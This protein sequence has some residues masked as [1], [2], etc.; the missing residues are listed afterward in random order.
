M[1]R[2]LNCVLFVAAINLSVNAQTATI[3]TIPAA[4]PGNVAVNISLAGFA[5]DISSFQWTIVYDT[6]VLT[7]INTTNWYTGVAGVGVYTPAANKITMVY[8]ESFGLPISGMLCTLNFTYPA[9]APCTNITWSDSPTPRLIADGLYNP[10]TV[11]WVNGQVCPSTIGITD[12]A[13]GQPFTAVYA[14]DDGNKVVVNYSFPAAGAF[15]AGL[16]NVSGQCLRSVAHAYNGQDMQREEFDTG[17]LGPGLYI[18]ACRM[19]TASECFVKYG[20]VIIAE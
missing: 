7:Y 16:Y 9:L 18:V 10:F 19:K 3:Q 13:S 8:G 6:A 2:F 5:P 11:T 17:D 1:N 20:K 14:S 12:H 15:A 4:V